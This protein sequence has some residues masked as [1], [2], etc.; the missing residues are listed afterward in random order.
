MGSDAEIRKIV[1][2]LLKKKEVSVKMGVSGEIDSQPLENQISKVW[3][4]GDLKMRTI[5]EV[6]KFGG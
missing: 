3:G 5:N 1:V 2:S 6:H 4:S